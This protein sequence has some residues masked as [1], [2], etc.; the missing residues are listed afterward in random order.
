MVD[1]PLFVRDL[2]YVIGAAL[3]GGVL[4]W[5]ARQ[6]L[7][8]GYVVGGIIIG[9]FTPGPTVS[10]VHTF[11]L[12]AEVAVV[13]LMFSIGIEFSLRD[14]LRVKWIAV[15][16]GPLGI[17]LSIALSL[18][19]GSALGW[20]GPQAIAVGAIVSV[21]STMV[22]ARLLLDQQALDTPLG[23]VMIGITLV[24][25]L[26][27]VI[28]TVVLPTLSALTPDRLLALAFALGRAGVIMVPFVF[29]AAW[30]VPRL[31]T[32]VVATANDELFLLVTL[33]I[34][35]GTAAVT[36]A[37]GLS[38]A[39]GAF[40]AGL[41]VNSSAHAHQTLLRLLPIR[42]IFVAL[43]FVTVGALIDPA[44]LVSHWRLVTV[45]VAMI[46]IGKF[47]IWTPIVRAFRYPWATAVSVGIGLGQI[48]EFS[49]V[50]VQVA[51]SAGQVGD[52]LYQATLAASVLTI[53]INGIG[54]KI[55]LRR[56]A[57]R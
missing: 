32:R 41:I 16:G 57:W 46:V 4:A 31:L 5:L 13:L 26:V 39:L 28:L 22:L 15:V 9:P 1:D 12:F 36:H 14:L 2:A 19:V 43:F 50:L 8:L 7:I 23:R 29:L 25:D 18:V 11:E 48:G 53:L 52:D 33:A 44:A 54:V 49:F 3:V 27:V 17:V 55:S 10:D 21:A 47:V 56:L 35:L 6:P 38:F 34:G 40:L 45:L 24:E 30:A 37:A 42:D 20:P 51:R